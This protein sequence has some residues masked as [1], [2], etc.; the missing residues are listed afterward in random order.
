VKAD[1]ELLDR[2]HELCGEGAI[3]LEKQAQVK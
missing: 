3:Q 2:L 1:D